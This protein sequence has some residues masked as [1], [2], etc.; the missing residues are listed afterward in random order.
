MK[1]ILTL[2]AA[3]VLCGSMAFAQVQKSVNPTLKQNNKTVNQKDRTSANKIVNNN[4][5]NKDNKT[6]TYTV[7]EMNQTGKAIDDAKIRLT[8]ANNDQL[9]AMISTSYKSTFKGSYV[10]YDVKDMAISKNPVKSNTQII[11]MKS[12]QPGEYRVQFVDT[13]GCEMNFKV[14]KK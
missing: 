1:K 5:I 14:I 13:K 3:V 2:A 8:Y 12:F 7:K 11:D 9:K 10:V 4:D 6:Y